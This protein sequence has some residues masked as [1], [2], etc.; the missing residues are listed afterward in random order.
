MSLDDVLFYLMLLVLLCVGL[1]L[2]K[3]AGGSKG[4]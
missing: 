4:K 1:C 2:A 3:Y